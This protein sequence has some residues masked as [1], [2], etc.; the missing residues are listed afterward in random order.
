MVPFIATTA[1]VLVAQLVMPAL[2]ATVHIFPGTNNVYSRASLRGNNSVTIPYS[3]E[4]T[5]HVYCIFIL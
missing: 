1:L 2:A 5:M 3:K 4:T